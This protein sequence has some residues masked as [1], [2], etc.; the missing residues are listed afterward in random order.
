[1]RQ[2]TLTVLFLSLLFFSARA[3]QSPDIEL[4]AAW[5]T[6]VSNLDWPNAYDKGDVEAQK[7]SF[8]DLLKSLQDIN[9][10]TIFFQVRTECDAF[11]VSD[12]EP[13]SRYLTGTQG[14]DPGYDPLKFAIEECHK[15]GMELHVWINPYRVNVS[16]YD[17]G[18]Y[19]A[20]NSVYRL[21][22]DWILTYDDGKKI[23][24]PGL[25]QVQNYIKKI[26]G[27]ILNKY[28]IDGIHM[29]DYFY[30]Y[31][32]TP[33][34]LDA[35]TYSQYGS[36]Y[37]SIG[38]FRRGSINKMV[39]N[40][41]DTI[42][43]VKPYVRFGISPFGIYGNGQN[44]P[45]IY[46]LDAYN[47]IYCDPLAWL[48]EGSVDYINP[49]LYWPTGG[50]QDFGKLLPWWAN[51]AFENNRDVFAGHGIYRL[52]SYPEI[53]YMDF[54]KPL[55]EYKDYFN[56][57]NNEMLR[58]AGWS[59]E[60]VIRQINIVRQNADKNALGS[61]F[62]RTKDFNRVHGLKDYLYEHVYKYK[63]L[64]PEQYWKQSATPETVTN[65]RLENVP[66]QSFY[67]IVWD[68]G[69]TLSRYAI[70]MVNGDLPDYN[71]SQN[72]IDISFDNYYI[73]VSD[74]ILDNPHIG[75]V[76]INRFW[77]QG[78]PSELFAIPKPEKP[79]L[80]SP[81]NN[82]ENMAK[83]G[84]F[85]W[86]VSKNAISYQ[87]EFS[88]KNDFST[89]YETYTTNDTVLSL[90]NINIEGETAYY[91][92]V[93]AVNIAGYSPYSEV[94][95]VTTGFPLTPE[96]IYP[97]NNETKVPLKPE[98]QFSV[99][100]NTD[101]LRLQ[102]TRGG[103]KFNIINIIIDTVFAKSSIFIPQKEFYRNTTHYA[104]IKA[105]NEFGAG[106]WSEIVKFKTLYPAP[107]KTTFVS[108]P[109]NSV[110]KEDKQEIEF[111]WNKADEASLYNFQISENKDFTSVIKDVDVYIGEKYT[112]TYPVK[113]K[114]LYA[115]VAGEN[116]GG[117]GP[118]SDTIRFIL[119][120]TI[121]TEDISPV[122][123]NIELYP[124][125][126]KDFVYLNLK[127][128]SKEIPVV[129]TIYNSTGAKTGE[130]KI[131]QLSENDIYDIDLKQILCSPC[132]IRVT[133]NKFSQTL[134]V[135]KTN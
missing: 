17:G 67:K 130:K 32:G 87:I 55:H 123:D 102:I 45:G 50:S 59:L 26:A 105:S 29:D 38:D 51:H 23:L 91:W 76:K 125:P 81:E 7:S 61:V 35:D 48:N 13:W 134:K 84:V 56:L 121:K 58:T 101:S 43:A 133:T 88:L 39:K 93:R 128:H 118:W 10:N 47:T 96:F 85:T 1:M 124:V 126:C 40:V 68:N 119:D 53:S 111:V 60:E 73:P 74:T 90:Q 103:T 104:R 129:I 28:D 107:N 33:Y 20:E 72:L 99:T 106:N 69:D 78:E 127:N 11:Y 21:H 25:P 109:N 92:R 115:R 79:I 49:Q 75:I 66:G 42:I 37:A 95:K 120:N 15:R 4:R 114:W 54:S 2:T 62:F 36:E 12:Y 3:Q 41:M 122:G 22:P 83:S 80:V 89:I 64:L 110:F 71:H 18:N 108:P 113:K 52:D 9:I 6:T 46:G 131:T 63:S 70:Y 65:I 132:F 8:I 117:Y 16:A 44:P 34:E 98:F 82:Y 27:D 19:Y 5:F 116:I 86:E 100:D 97:A 24:N 31:S 112:Y 77:K 30:S 94:R 57:S 14:R 135:L